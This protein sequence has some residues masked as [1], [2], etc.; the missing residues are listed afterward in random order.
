[1]RD[2]IEVM[3]GKPGVRHY[4]IKLAHNMEKPFVHHHK[5]GIT[6]KPIKSHRW[7]ELLDP[8]TFFYRIAF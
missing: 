3:L 2:E 5:S 8:T 1:V 6:H 7:H 4:T